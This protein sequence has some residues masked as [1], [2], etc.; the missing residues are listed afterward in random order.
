M[1]TGHCGQTAG[2]RRV[3]QARP[4]EEEGN[5]GHWSNDV[6]EFGDWTVGWVAQRALKC[7]RLVPELSGNDDRQPSLRPVSVTRGTGTRYEWIRAW[8]GRSFYTRTD[9]HWSGGG[10]ESLE[11]RDL[12]PGRMPRRPAPVGGGCRGSRDSEEA[13]VSVKKEARRSSE[14]SLST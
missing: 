13:R 3:A 2:Y 1:G 8:K 6:Q 9:E 14:T 12:S 10:G 11:N 7:P 4:V 5:E